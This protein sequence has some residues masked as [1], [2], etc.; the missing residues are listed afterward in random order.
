MNIKVVSA[1]VEKFKDE[2]VETLM[3]LIKIP[4]ILSLIH[5]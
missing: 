1:E 3:E 5:I 4:A 2:M